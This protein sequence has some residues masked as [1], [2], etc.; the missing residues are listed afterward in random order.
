M[1]KRVLRL[2]VLVPGLSIIMVVTVSAEPI[3]KWLLKPEIHISGTLNWLTS[4]DLT[5]GKNPGI[6]LSQPIACA[7]MPPYGSCMIV[8]Y[9]NDSPLF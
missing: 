9:F 8:L 2:A 1:L 7:T 6:L 4:Q 3:P 5:P